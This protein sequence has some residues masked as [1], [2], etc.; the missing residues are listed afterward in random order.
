MRSRARR[1]GRAAMHSGPRRGGTAGRAPGGSR[2]AAPTARLP[3]LLLAAPASK[4]AAAATAPT[5]P[6]PPAP[7]SSDVRVSMSMTAPMASESTMARR[8]GGGARAS[9]GR[10]ASVRSPSTAAIRSP[11]VLPPPPPPPCGPRACAGRTGGR[12]RAAASGSRRPSAPSAA[13]FCWMAAATSPPSQRLPRARAAWATTTRT[14]VALDCMW[15]AWS[16]ETSGG[17][18]RACSGLGRYSGVAARWARP[19]TP[20][21]GAPTRSPRARARAA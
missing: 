4:S 20:A 9:R 2:S 14:W 10:V 1:A 6:P 7:P 13:A 17:S 5:V 16:V 12:T 3:R 18:S 11:C 19:R 8:L 15:A 21:P